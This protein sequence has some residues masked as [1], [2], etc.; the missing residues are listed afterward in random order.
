MNKIRKQH[1]SKMKAKVALEAIKSE[2][3]L[4]EIGHRFG[5]HPKQVGR[6][7]KEL[8][9]RAHE[10]FS[11]DRSKDAKLVESSEKELLEMI[12]KLKVENEFLK[13]KSGIEY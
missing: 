12:G 5:I 1:G 7:R 13:K 8:V 2:E 10:V 4:S 9:E 6:W 11:E 3:T